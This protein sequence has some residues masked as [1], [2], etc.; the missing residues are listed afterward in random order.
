MRKLA[1]AFL[2]LLLIALPVLA[3]P[4]IM[5]GKLLGVEQGDYAHI[6]VEDESG[7]SHSFFVSNDSSFQQLLEFPEKFTDRQVEIRWQTVER[8]IPEA[9]GKQQI[10][11]A[12]SITYGDE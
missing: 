6:T 5:R 10:D 11:E 3:E 9:G 8:N 12:M 7:E 4:Q 1:L 2:W